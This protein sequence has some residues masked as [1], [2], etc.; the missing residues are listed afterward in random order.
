MSRHNPTEQAMDPN[1]VLGA[2]E[3][4]TAG[5]MQGSNLQQGYD[6]QQP[7]RRT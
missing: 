2:G 3:P 5:R 4:G 7:E 6:T 1:Q